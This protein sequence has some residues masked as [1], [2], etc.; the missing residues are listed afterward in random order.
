LIDLS[1]ATE[2]I[3]SYPFMK[4]IH[5]KIKRYEQ[6]DL[7]CGPNSLAQLLSFYGDNTTPEEIVAK[8]NMIDD[9][10]VFDAQLGVT[11]IKF[12]YKVRITP[13]NLCAFDPTWYELSNAEL[14][15]KL[16]NF[17]RKIT[18]ELLK[19]DID[20]FISFL[21]LGGQID[22]RPISKELLITKL[23][24]YPILVGL[25]STYL[26]REKRPNRWDRRFRYSHSVIVNGYDPMGD[27]FF[28]TDPWHSIPRSKTG[29]YQIKSDELIAAIFLAEAT[30]SATVMEVWK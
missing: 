11:A 15:S 12:G 18:D 21:K 5:H 1:V 17:S 14:I 26:W 3:E 6:T 23:K 28:I 22:L 24:K 25:C 8:T 29:F 16:R 10:G 27:K 2:A 19:I 7:N 20:A 30:Y 9:L 4:K 13:Q